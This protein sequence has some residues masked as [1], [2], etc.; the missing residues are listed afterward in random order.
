MRIVLFGKNIFRIYQHHI[1]EIRYET[2]CKYKSVCKFKLQEIDTDSIGS[3]IELVGSTISLRNL[4]RAVKNNKSFVK[5][6]IFKNS[7]GCKA[8]T[9]WVMFRGGNDIEYKIRNIEAYIFNVYV[10]QAYRGNGFAGEM[11][12]Q[13]MN[14]LHLK[15][16]ENAYLAVSIK[17]SSAIKAYEKVGFVNVYDR[18]F[19]RVLKINIPYHIL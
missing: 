17:N 15:G 3:E 9:I 16:I 19:A 1:M 14:I 7:A 10:N 5:G 4:E 13:L 12:Y 18:K 2:L 6:F 8:G 11:I